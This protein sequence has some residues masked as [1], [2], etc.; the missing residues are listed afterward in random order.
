MS[1]LESPLS[2]EPVDPSDSRPEEAER[3]A[4]GVLLAREIAD[5]R[6]TAQVDADYEAILEKVRQLK[7]LFD[8]D[9]AEAG[10]SDEISEQIE[11]AKEILG[12][13]LLGP[14]QIKN[15]F[16]SSVE[17]GEIPP[18]PFSRAELEGAKE[19]DQMLILRLPLSMAQIR[20][21]L[22]GKLKDGT[23]LLYASNETTGELNADCW[24]RNE[25]FYTTETASAG[26]ALVSKETIP[27]STDKDYWQQTLAL[28]S[29]FKDR[30]FAGVSLLEQYRSALTELDQY[31]AANFSGKSPEG[32]NQLLRGADSDRYAGEISSLSI[33]QLTRQ[34]P[35]EA[36]YDLVVYFQ[37]NTER[38]LPKI[39]SWTK[40]LSSGGWLVNVGRFNADGAN[41]SRYRPGFHV[42]DLGV[43]VSRQS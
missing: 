19:L 43:S 3:E 16:G 25:P 13:D 26:W 31:A 35:A 38:L 6:R 10:V 39:H 18:I 7:A 23:K 1:E 21:A 41:V 20:E 4:R 33:N 2:Q 36:I 5:L 34:S 32:I 37:N 42:G 9:S 27:D 17:I 28:A 24:Y 30:I 14:D 12:A 15:A 40:R 22:G 8:I 29:Y 11:Q